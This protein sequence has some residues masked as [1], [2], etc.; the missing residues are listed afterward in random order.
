MGNWRC[1]TGTQRLQ[2]LW[3]LVALGLVAVTAAAEEP[4]EVLPSLPTIL[5]VGGV[6]WVAGLVV[7]GLR[8]RRQWNAM[9]E[10]TSFVPQQGPH[11]A[12]LERIVEGRTVTVTTSVPG[13]FAQTHTEIET[14]VDGV[15]ASFTV[16]FRYVETGGRTRGRQTGVEEL[17]ERFVSTGSEENVARLLSTDVQS[18]LLAVR[19][20]GVC[21]VTGEAVAYDVPFTRLTSEELDTLA[22]LVVTI[23]RRVERVDR[24]G[25]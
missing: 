24:T 14:A 12:D 5:L 7:L 16:R 9:V 22:A 19:T 25:V 23:A 15:E 13:L 1:Y 21:T 6:G 20:P 2:L 18:A 4:V 17:D 3:T 8:E 10:R 11:A